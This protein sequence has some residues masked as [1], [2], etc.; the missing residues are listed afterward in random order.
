ENL[1]RVA[2]PT[3]VQNALNG[4]TSYDFLA[5]R[6]RD[7]VLREAFR[8]AVAKLS[9]SKGNDPGLWRFEPGAIRSTDPPVPYGNRG[10]YILIVELRPIPRARTV[11]A[12]GVAERGPHANDQT[13]L[14]EGWRYKPIAIRP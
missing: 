10:T 8:R 6:K 7:E 11:L 1:R 9:A 12:P 3:F 14:A 13:P 2:Q 5:G 4:R